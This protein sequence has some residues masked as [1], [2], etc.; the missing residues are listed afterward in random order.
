LVIA[1]VGISNLSFF[2]AAVAQRCSVAGFVAAPLA[3]SSLNLFTKLKTG[4]AHASR[5]AN[6]PPWIFCDVRQISGVLLAAVTVRK[7]MGV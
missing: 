3:Y 2:S 1:S 7:P 4:Q 5:G 6:R